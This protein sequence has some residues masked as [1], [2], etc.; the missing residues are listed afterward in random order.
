MTFKTLNQSKSYFY[1][2]W[3]WTNHS[4]KSSMS[5]YT[6]L[7]LGKDFWRSDSGLHVSSHNL[8]YEKL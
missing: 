2:L 6:H 5:G 7:I 4:E 1:V 8:S 3:Y